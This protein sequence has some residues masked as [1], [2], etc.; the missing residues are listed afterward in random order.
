MVLY[1]SI[2]I[3]IIILYHNLMGPLSYMLSVVDRNVVM[4][5]IPVQPHCWETRIVQLSW[6]NSRVISEKNTKVSERQRPPKLWVYIPKRRCASP[7]ILLFSAAVTT[8]TFTT[9]HSHGMPT[10]TKELLWLTYLKVTVVMRVLDLN[11][12]RRQTKVL[13]GSGV[14][15]TSCRAYS[16]VNTGLLS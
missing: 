13:G 15:T 3:Y 6:D 4:R 10:A 16:S 9:S 8:S 2:I 5:R 11:G 7:N 12:T 1:Y 14:E